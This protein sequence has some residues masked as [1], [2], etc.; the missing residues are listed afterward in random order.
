[1]TFEQLDQSIDAD[2]DSEDEAAEQA[3]LYKSK[4]NERNPYLLHTLIMLVAQA[5]GKTNA[6]P[7]EAMAGLSLD[8]SRSSPRAAP[9]TQLSRPVQPPDDE[10]DEESVE[11]DDEDNPFG[12]RNAVQ[13][14]QVEKG[15][16]RW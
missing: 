7:T 15:Q 10:S 13:T 16:P 14:P 11:E 1:M 8:K 12:D 3:H 4:S 9:P 5:K 2:S 6:E